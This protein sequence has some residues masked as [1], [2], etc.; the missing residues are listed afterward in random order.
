[1]SAITMCAH[2]NFVSSE[3]AC[4]RLNAT[5]LGSVHLPGNARRTH[6]RRSRHYLFTIRRSRAGESPG[7]R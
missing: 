2:P 1:M 7:S 6:V 3:H 5:Q 4:A